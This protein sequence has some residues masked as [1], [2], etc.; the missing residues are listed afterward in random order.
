MWLR[1]GMFQASQCVT[2]FHHACQAGDTHFWSYPSWNVGEALLCLDMK[3][4]NPDSK[5]GQQL[6]IY[7]L[8]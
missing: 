6:N 4:K 7:L 2:V 5:S 1:S 8:M 3:R